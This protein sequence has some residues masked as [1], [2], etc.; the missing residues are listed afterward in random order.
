MSIHTDSRQSL[1]KQTT[2]K[3]WETPYW[4][5]KYLKKIYPFQWDMAA[6]KRNRICENYVNKKQDATSI[7][8]PGNTVIFCNPPYDSRQLGKWFACGWGAARRNS[9]VVFLVHGRSDTVWYYEWAVR[10]TIVA[11]RSRFKF[12]YKGIELSSATFPSIFVI[13]TKNHVQDYA[14]Y[15]ISKVDYYRW[16]PR[17]EHWPL[18]KRTPRTI[19][20]YPR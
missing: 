13:F 6:S 9:T 4:L 20:R 14:K 19:E 1:F 17:K 16:W 2:H 8:W 11:V 5:V 7:K 10:G 12:L 15:G 18:L 3:K